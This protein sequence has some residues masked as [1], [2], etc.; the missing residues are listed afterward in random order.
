VPDALLAVPPKA[1][2]IVFQRVDATLQAERF[3]GIIDDP[4]FRGDADPL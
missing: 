3:N 1:A 4:R 2:E